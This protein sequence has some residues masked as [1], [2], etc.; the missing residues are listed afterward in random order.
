MT[1]EHVGF[2]VLERPERLWVLAFDNA[3]IW[4]TRV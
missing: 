4:L 2:I 3:V 1:L